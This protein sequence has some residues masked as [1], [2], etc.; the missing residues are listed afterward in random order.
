MTRR[1]VALLLVVGSAAAV[2]ATSRLGTKEHPLPIYVNPQLPE[3]NLDGGAFHP[4]PW[5]RLGKHRNRVRWR[6]L[7]GRFTQM[8][9][10]PAGTNVYQPVYSKGVVWL[11]RG[12]F[13]LAASFTPSPQAS[14]THFDYG[15]IPVEFARGTGNQLWIDLQPLGPPP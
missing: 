11:P 7:D 4:V 13:R 15:P 2:N 5:R 9:V 6:Q 3:D 10:A 12:S 1:W 8:F 14:V